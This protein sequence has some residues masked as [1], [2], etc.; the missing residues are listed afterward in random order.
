[1]WESASVELGHWRGAGGWRYR[2][3]QQLTRE[4][5]VFRLD[6]RPPTAFPAPNVLIPSNITEIELQGRAF[7]LAN[8]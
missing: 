4:N 8:V 3:S 1:M 6:Y 2:W 7:H 5:G